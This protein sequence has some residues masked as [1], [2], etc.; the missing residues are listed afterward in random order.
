MASEAEVAGLIRPKGKKW[1]SFEHCLRQAQTHLNGATV[2]STQCLINN[3]NKHK[4]AS[5]PPFA[6]GVAYWR[7]ASVPLRCLSP[8]RS[9]S[10]PSQRLRSGLPP[11]LG[12]LS[13]TD[14][15]TRAKTTKTRY[16][17]DPLIL[18]P[19]G[20]PFDYESCTLTLL[21]MTSAWSALKRPCVKNSIAVR[22][23][24]ILEVTLFSNSIRNIYITSFDPPTQY[25]I[26]LTIFVCFNS[27]GADTSPE[28][29]R[30][31]VRKKNG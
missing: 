7:F 22:L 18:I 15:E 30:R 24:Q 19:V 6:A 5:S 21:T 25:S 16:C 27:S 14:T 20:Y 3:K 10:P 2:R 9:P 26:I 4:I 31:G 11:P 8:L 12:S 17:F 13:D 28:Q 1:P 23:S 29:C